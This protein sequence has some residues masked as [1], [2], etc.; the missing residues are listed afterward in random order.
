M[1]L[2]LNSLECLSLLIEKKIVIILYVYDTYEY[3]YTHT[4]LIQNT[5]QIIYLPSATLNELGSQD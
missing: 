3:M 4:I 2:G 1:V 5:I